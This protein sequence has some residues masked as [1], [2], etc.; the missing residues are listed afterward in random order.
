MKSL[1]IEVIRFLLGCLVVLVFVGIFCAVVVVGAKYS[2]GQTSNVVSC[3]SMST[4]N[5]ITSSR[6]R[7][8]YSTYVKGWR[9][10]ETNK[11][12]TFSSREGDVCTVVDVN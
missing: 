10:Y 6:G 5:V 11:I 3:K 9:N 7:W 12:E 2:K 1:N 4:G 8:D